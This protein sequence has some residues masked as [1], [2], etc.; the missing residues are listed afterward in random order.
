VT[1]NVKGNFATNWTTDGPQLQAIGRQMSH[2]DPD[3]ITFNE[4]P[5]GKTY[6]MTNFI[7]VFLP[8]Y[9]M[10]TNSGVAA[11]VI[12]SVIL[13]R[14]PITRSQAWLSN[15]SLTNF[16]YAGTFTRDLFEAEITVP[17]ASEPL[18]VF[19]THLK[20]GP[21]VDSQDRRAAEANCVSNFLVTVFIPSHGYRPYVL[22]GDLNETF[23]R[24]RDR[25]AT[26]DAAQSVHALVLHSFDP[27]QQLA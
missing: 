27:R 13:S 16:G 5:Y 7:N 10:A 22:A 17:G 14:Y 20:S 26:D 12:R 4:I 19:T 9:F 11:D 1:Y 21:D 3:I 23:D 2:L 18:H 15:A 25:P 8:G 6:E 24:R